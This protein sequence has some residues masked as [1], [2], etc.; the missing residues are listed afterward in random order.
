MTNPEFLKLDEN[1]KERLE[2]FKN[3]PKFSENSLV[4]LGEFLFKIDELPIPH[5]LFLSD[6]GNLVLSWRDNLRG[7]IE[8]EFLDQKIFYYI[9]TLKLED[10]SPIIEVLSLINKVK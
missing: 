1:S 5:S 4:T 3:S 2:I 10:Y 9:E 7:I 6:D 8:L